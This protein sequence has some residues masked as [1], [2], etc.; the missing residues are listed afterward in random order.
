MAQPKTIP[1]GSPPIAKPKTIPFG[2]AKPSTPP[3]KTTGQKVAN[4]VMG[5]SNF[6]GTTKLGQG[7]STIFDSTSEKTV[8]QRGKQDQ[9]DQQ[10]IINAIHAQ[11]DPVK[12]QRLIDFL[13][14]Q[15]GQDYKSPTAEQLNPGFGL[16]NKEV[17]GSA[18]Q[19]ALN[20]VGAG[21]SAKTLIGKTIEGAALGYGF[22][23]AQQATD[24]K[25][26]T[27]A[28]GVGTL[29]GALLP[30]ATKLIG[31]ALKRV[32]GTTT[33]VGNK[34]LDRTVKNP[35]EVFQNMRI[36]NTDESKMGLV[37]RAKEAIGSFIEGRNTEFGSAVKGMKSSSAISKSVIT[38]AF[39]NEVDKFGGQVKNGVLEFGDTSLN[40]GEQKAISDVWG[41]IKSW[42]DVTPSGLD[43]LRQRIG[44]EMDN[45]KFAGN[46]RESVVL[47]NVKKALTNAMTSN[48]EGYGK[49]L[50]TYGEKTR[51]AKE[52]VSEL[53]QK[54]NAKPSTQL[55]SILKLFKK[56]PSVIKNLTK[57]MGEE[58]ANKFLNQISGAVLSDLLP[59]SVKQQWLEGTLGASQILSVL[60]GT[61]K[62]GT[63]LK[64]GGATLA[65]FSPKIVGT[66]AVLTG[67]AIKKGVGTGIQRTLTKIGSKTNR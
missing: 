47:G 20:V 35:D 4:A 54:G 24:N 64:T 42:K 65:T 33:G 29:T 30:L 13:K 53:N 6:A 59:S 28:P 15:F 58:Q 37:Q 46:G 48:I 2:N 3:Q 41:V 18:A 23:K 49:T 62:V 66:G 1:F 27:F 63:A 21:A 52:L 25:P 10:S 31:T 26:M 34:V 5:V 45:F 12:K 7:I 36:Y 17:L 55:N 50:S 38:D 67:K 32:L 14:R 16:S 9:T 11:T 8:A 56:D 57:V 60:A 61:L 40:T 51:L 19:T 22:D 43:T 44:N 39:A